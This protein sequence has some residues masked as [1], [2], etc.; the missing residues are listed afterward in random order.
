MSEKKPRR[1][2]RKRTAVYSGVSI[3]LVVFLIVANVLTLGVYDLTIATYLGTITLKNEVSAEGLDATYY[4]STP[5]INSQ[6][7]A[8]ANAKLVNQTICDEGIA[9]LKNDTGALPFAPGT[10]FSLFSHSSVDWV[11]ATSGSGSIK[12]ATATDADRPQTLKE[13]FEDNGL[14]VNETLWNFYLT[15]NGSSYVRGAGAAFFG[16][17]QDFQIHECPASVLAAEPGLEETYEGTVAVF[18]L[19]RT[20]GEGRGL[21]RSMAEQKN[22]LEEDLDKSYAEPDSVEL[23]VI[24]YLQNNDAFDEIVLIV[25]SNTAV[26]LGWVED[27]SKI[28]TVLNI[29]ATGSAGIGA[30]A[31]VLNGTVTPSGHTVDTFVTNAFSSPAAANVDEGV[32][33]KNGD[34]SANPDYNH[35]ESFAFG[36]NSLINYYAYQEGIYVGYRYYETRYEDCIL[37]NGGA[38]SSVGSID[39]EAWDYAKEVVYPF[40]FGLSTTTFEWSNFATSWDGTDCTVTVDVKN[41]GERAGKDVVQ[42]YIQ[43]PYTDY[44][45]ENGVEKSAVALAG[46]AK[47]DLLEP[48]ASQ[49]VSVTFSEEAF[50]AYD[51]N[52]A[53]TY[54]LDAGTYYITAAQD[55]HAAIN[56]IILAKD[57]SKADL[58]IP[59]PAETTAGDASFVDT[60]EYTSLNDVIYSKDTTTG[61][62]ITN[63]FDDCQ[64]L[65]D[66]A[67]PEDESILFLTRNDWAGTFP[68][69]PYGQVDTHLESVYQNRVNGEGHKTYVY[70]VAISE[71][72]YARLASTNSLNPEQ[73][74]ENKTHTDH[75][76]FGEQNGL[77]FSDMRGVPLDDERWDLLV[78][79]LT[80]D[81]V[82]ALLSTNNSY[83]ECPSINKALTNHSGGP[84]GF[85]N[86]RVGYNSEPMTGQTWNV[87]MAALFGESMGND[88]IWNI[89]SAAGSAVVSVGA[90]GVNIHRSPFGGRS[91]EYYSEDPVLSAQLAAAEIRAGAEKGIIYKLKHF[92]LNEEENGR[93]DGG[94]ANN[95]T[96]W[97]CAVFC[98]EQAIREIYLKAFEGAIKGSG[99]VEFKYYRSNAAGDLELV[100][101]QKPALAGIMTSFNRIGYTWAGGCY[102]L[103]T[104]ILRNEWGFDGHVVSDMDH[105]G[106]MDTVQ[107]LYAGGDSKLCGQIQT[108]YDGTQYNVANATDTEAWYIRNAIKHVLFADVNSF[109]TQG[110]LPGDVSTSLPIHHIIVYAVDAV[111]GVALV[112]ML[113]LLSRQLMLRKR[114]KTN[115]N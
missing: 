114:E 62:A 102:P 44:D 115:S 45:K 77:S 24:E 91:A 103:V 97:G 95:G 73:T 110:M 93:G 79:Q 76:V 26:E 87:E 38:D 57:P 84:L 19:S 30:V 17:E 65:D 104:G 48:G 72:E 85:V 20:C 39:G 99:T 14:A 75:L 49:A 71:E 9:L 66:P 50:K 47:T 98:N 34:W 59:S 80:V 32:L 37:G 63:L 51:A 64:R 36:E 92:A 43:S 70:S 74:A 60:K 89:N 1:Y 56:N 105:G 22:T 3:L 54:I 96:K 58:L 53:K 55:A 90:P 40:G 16:R 94:G 33:V 108:M 78:N 31:R 4:Q 10:T 83:A 88:M 100:T 13:A 68:A 25:N 6:E 61:V 23:G 42:I 28:N 5:G 2:S 21:P 35:G 11:Y 46:F 8:V 82:N 112:V 69:Q 52:N 109:A 12:A 106:N 15:G 29:P 27:Y 101:E 18:V 113:V 41:T 81:E 67:T 7:E 111:L 86:A 107:M